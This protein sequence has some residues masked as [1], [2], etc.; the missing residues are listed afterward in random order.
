MKKT[1]QVTQFV[2]VEVDETKF[3]PEFME[4]FQNVFF[5]FETI[6]EHL[7]HLA[8]LEARG[9]IRGDFIEGYGHQKD[10]GI[11]IRITD[12]ETELVNN[13]FSGVT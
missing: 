3:T 9:V 6:D 10:M 13:E 11:R 1:V 5:K 12:M 2:E 4:M 8:Q 7:E